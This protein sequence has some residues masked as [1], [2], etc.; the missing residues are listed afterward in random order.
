MFRYY[1][2]RREDRDCDLIIVLDRQ[3]VEFAL[4]FFTN[5]DSPRVY[6]DF[7]TFLKEKNQQVRIKLVKVFVSGILVSSIPFS[8]FTAVYAQSQPG[9]SV[10]EQIAASAYSVSAGTKFSMAYLYG[11]TVD[12]QIEQVRLAGTLNTVSP[13]YFDIDKNGALQV[14]SVSQKLIDAMHDMGIRVVPMLSNHWDRNAGRLALRDPAALAEQ[15]AGYVE[16]YGLDGVNVDIENVTEKER[17]AYTLLVKTLREVIPAHK[18]VSVAVAANP[19]G[20]QTGWHGSYD[21]AA[22]ARYADYLMIMAYDESW[23]GGEAGPVAS[24]SFAE[25]SI[26]YALRFA[27]AEKL[28]LGVPFYGRVWS[29]DGRFTGQGIT[30]NRLYELLEDYASV[31][32]Y[33]ETHQSP[34]VEITVKEGDPIVS[35]GG[36]TLSPGK[37]TIWFEDERSLEAKT[38]LIHAYNLKGLGAWALHQATDSILGSLSGWLAEPETDGAMRY[39]RVTATSLRVRRGPSLQSEVIGYYVQDERVEVVG[40]INGWYRVRLSG[41]GYG[42]ASADYIELEETSAVTER[43]GYAAGDGVWVRTTP[44]GELLTSLSFGEAFTVLGEQEDGW[45]R[46]RL[47]DGREGFVHADYVSFTVPVRERTGYAAGDGVWV[48]T[49]P[50]GELLTSLSFGEAFTVLGEQEDGWYR[51]RLADG[52]EGFVHADYVSFTVP[53][54]E[55]AGYAAGDGVWVRSTPSGELLTS[56]SFGE[57]FTVL[58]EQEDGWYRVRLADGREGFVHADY[59][60]FTVPVRERAGYSSGSN[61]RVRSAPSTSGNILAHLSFGEAFTVLGERQGDWFQ[62]R[63]A[64]GTEGFVHADYVS[65]TVPIRERAGYSSGSNVRVRSSPSTSGRILAHLAFAEAFTVLGERQGDWFQ[66]RLA[67]GTKGYVHADYVSFTVPVRE[68]D[69]YSSGSNVRVRSTPSTS[70]RIL[71]TLS[72]GQRFTVIGEKEGSWYRVRLQNGTLGYVHANYVAF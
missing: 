27:P 31:L 2:S 71:A 7:L 14:G 11:G 1:I 13:G 24:L 59:V 60:S 22:L 69:G 52:R 47:A 37:Y 12:R 58:G 40:E 62:V 16:Q 18:E 19:N 35:L 33:S 43:T 9:S 53:V 63:L 45:Y 42:Y 65:F 46:V 4:E 21:Y 8:L 55:R 23:E 10:A 56:L 64:N 32:F 29:G 61:V 51:V 30:L 38:E 44:S 26:Q 6:R 68:R 48:R 70:G 25:R 5:R 3:D 20:W 34:M 57:A 41:G 49:T 36:K 54:R 15:I 72:K 39:G 17:D 50:S 28:V 67:D 66:V